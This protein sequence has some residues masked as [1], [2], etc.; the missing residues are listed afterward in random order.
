MNLSVSLLRCGCM[1]LTTVVPMCGCAIVSLWEAQCVSLGRGFSL[2]VCMHG[3]SSECVCMCD[4]VSVLMSQCTCPVCGHICSRIYVCLV[5]C[6]L[7]PSTHGY[8]SVS[9]VYRHLGTCVCSWIYRL[10][11]SLVA[12]YMYVSCEVC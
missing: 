5:V 6:V 11:L 2:F 9:G 8:K 3:C 7:V 10:L 4:P 1:G 12:V